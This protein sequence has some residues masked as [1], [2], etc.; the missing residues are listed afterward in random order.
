M[1]SSGFFSSLTE[2]VPR[3]QSGGHY[4]FGVVAPEIY[5]T[6]RK[7]HQAYNTRHSRFLL[8]PGPF[9]MERI[10]T[11]SLHHRHAHADGRPWFWIT[12]HRPADRLVHRRSGGL[13][14]LPHPA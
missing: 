12:A 2:E 4:V 8:S 1:T 13:T 5:G 6:S 9:Y 7:L 11:A 14:D 10:L 3:P